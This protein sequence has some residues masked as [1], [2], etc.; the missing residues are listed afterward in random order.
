MP[1]ISN[2]E[3][4]PLIKKGDIRTI[5][6]CISAIENQSPDIEE[7]LL[8]IKPDYN[9]PVTGI[10][11]SPGAGKSTLLNQVL[12]HLSEKN[13][14]IAVLAID[15]SSPFNFG[16]LLGD[17]VRM[18]SH[19]NNPRIF[20]RS[21]A[22]RGSLGGLSS[23]TIETVDLLRSAPFD[24]IFVETVGV[25]QSEVEIAGLADHTILVTTPESGDDVQLIKAGIMEIASMFVVNKSDLD[26]EGKF[27]NQLKKLVFNHDNPDESPP[28]ISVQAAKNKG[29]EELITILE[30]G[31][32]KPNLTKKATLLAAKTIRLIQEMQTRHIDF[33]AIKSEISTHLKKGEFNLY[34]FAKKY[35]DRSENVRQKR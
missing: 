23:R 29:L 14:R 27:A 34:S 3:L 18:H 20:I 9:I 24:H 19:S 1:N 17:R 31:R 4:I 13:L 8:N 26:P 32:L 30:S 11:G 2:E 21:I 7:L 5:A 6:R 22:S 10:T 25:G 15:P 35:V 12:E 28:V 16:A 33:E